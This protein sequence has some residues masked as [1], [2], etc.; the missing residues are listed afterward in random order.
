[1]ALVNKIME[2][3]RYNEYTGFFDR[4]P[5]II[6]AFI[7]VLAT[8]FIIALKEKFPLPFFSGGAVLAQE[9]SAELYPILIASPSS[10]QVFNFVGKNEYVPI[11]IKSKEIEGLDYNLNLMINSKDIIKTFS[12]P[13]YKHDWRPDKPGEYTVAANLVNDI[14]QTLSSSNKIKFSVKFEYDEE[15]IAVA[16]ES[17]IINNSAEEASVNIAPVITLEVFE[18]PTYSAG[19]DICFYRVKATAS[20]NPTPSVSFSKDDSKGAWGPF[21]TQINLTRNSPSYTLTAIVKNSAG[22]SFDSITLDW[23]CE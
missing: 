10:E 23:S 22:Q 8:I 12:S 9:E 20:G 3:K 13:P 7:I 16:A 1:M 4:F 14:N 21:K 2:K 17:V 11:E 5:F 18:G 6:V 19:D 15:V